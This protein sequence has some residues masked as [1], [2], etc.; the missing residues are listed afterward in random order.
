MTVPVAEWGTLG[1]FLNFVSFGSTVVSDEYTSD[2]LVAHNSYEIVGG[3]SYGTSL[4]KGWGLGLTAKLFY[5]DLSS[6]ASVGGEYALTH[7]TWIERVV[8]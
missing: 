4:G 1:F 2:D 7:K 6:G 5:S 3:F 8:K